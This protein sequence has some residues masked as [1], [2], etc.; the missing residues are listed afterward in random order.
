M[1]NGFLNTPRGRTLIFHDVLKLFLLMSFTCWHHAFN[2]LLSKA[3]VYA[4][5]YRSAWQRVAVSIKLDS[6]ASYAE[7]FMRQ[8]A[9]QSCKTPENDWV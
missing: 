4:C 5:F 6:L 2:H 3:D 7:V 9:R 8:Y 1:W